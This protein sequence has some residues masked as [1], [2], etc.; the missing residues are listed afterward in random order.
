MVLRRVLRVGGLR[1]RGDPVLADHPR[2]RH[3]P[4]GVILG[5]QPWNFP[6]YQVVRFAGPNLVLGLDVVRGASLTGSERG[7]ASVGA[8]PGAA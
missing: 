2:Q 6:V 4:L 1:D 7:G 8:P 5:V 3:D